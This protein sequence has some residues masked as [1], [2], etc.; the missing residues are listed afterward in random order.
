MDRRGR[1]RERVER[2]R[3]ALV[4]LVTAPDRATARRLARALVGER[5]AAC[6][7]VVPGL[8]SIYRWKGAVRDDAEVLLLLKTRRARLAPLAARVKALHPYSIPEI[9]ALSVSSGNAPYLAWLRAAT[10]RA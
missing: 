6:A 10:G 2:A 5:L 1:R 3:N 4:V 9:L 7:N 8:R